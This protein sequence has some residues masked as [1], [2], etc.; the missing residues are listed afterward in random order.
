MIHLAVKYFA[1]ERR[2]YSSRS[3]LMTFKI[4]K[5]GKEK[6]TYTDE[7]AKK[8]KELEE[9]EQSDTNSNN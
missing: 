6:I 8:L 2:L 3:P 4:D 9:E 1:P 7:V 5:D